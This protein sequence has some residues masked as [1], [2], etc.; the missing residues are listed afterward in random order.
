MWGFNMIL[1]TK[2]R[3]KIKYLLIIVSVLFVLVLGL[4]LP[5]AQISLYLPN[6]IF[7][8]NYEFKLNQSIDKPLSALNLIPA[9]SKDAIKAQEQKNYILLDSIDLAFKK[10]DLISALMDKIKA[11]I[12]PDEKVSQAKLRYELTIKNPGLGEIKVY[13]ETV[14][15]PKINADE[16]KNNIYGKTKKTALEYLYALPEIQDV[17]IKTMPSKL[18][19]IPPIKA[20]IIINEINN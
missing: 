11:Q 7:A 14:I 8:Q 10:R 1:D 17:E 2:G 6:K 19:F 20:R 4:I 15:V 3:R 16:I 18:F 13:A 12:S 5:K 9:V